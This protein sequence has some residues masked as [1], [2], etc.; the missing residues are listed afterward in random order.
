M[1]AFV[2]LVRRQDLW[3]ESAHGWMSIG[4]SRAQ[5][6]GLTCRPDAQGHP[7]HN[8]FCLST[9][10]NIFIVWVLNWRSTLWLGSKGL[11][12]SSVKPKR[13]F[14]LFVVEW[15]TGWVQGDGLEMHMCLSFS[16][17]HWP[18]GWHTCAIWTDCQ[19]GQFPECWLCWWHSHF[20]LQLACAWNCS[21]HTGRWSLA[22]GHIGGTCKLQAHLCVRSIYLVCSYYPMFCGGMLFLLLQRIHLNVCTA[23]SSFIS[24]T[25]A[26]ILETKGKFSSACCAYRNLAV[27]SRNTLVFTKTIV[28]LNCSS[29]IVYTLNP[30]TMFLSTVPW[31]KMT[32]WKLYF[33]F[34]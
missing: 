26:C 7:K 5:S 24:K 10:H 11:H 1:S 33:I 32:V 30:D 2:W 22:S 4:T 16:G 28:L 29:V 14:R 8:F 17:Q 3:F 25:G 13:L 34:K 27:R 20:A 6:G 18:S 12:S 19:W 15:R 9:C 21:Q 23:V 31:Q